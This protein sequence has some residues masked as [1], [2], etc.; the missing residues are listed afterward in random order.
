MNMNHFERSNRT[1]FGIRLIA[2]LEA[3]G[4]LILLLL[5]D[6][7][8][9]TGDRFINTNPHP[10]WIPVLLIAV[11]YG[12]AE[13]LMAAFLACLFFLVGNIPAQPEGMDHYDYLYL[14]MINPILWV[15]AGWGLGE[16]RQ[17]HVRER[18]VLIKEIN[19]SQQREELISTSYQ[20]V[21][22]RKEA[23][24]VQVLDDSTD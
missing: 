8:F 9:Y 19:E 15:V 4:M 11:Q 24:E 21:K 16:L 17:R 12:T 18:D 7:F 14:L 1:I 2:I 6:R 10:F 3:V 20:F 22:N 23:L 5:V 13:G